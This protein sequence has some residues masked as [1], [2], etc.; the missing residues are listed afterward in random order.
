M[1]KRLFGL[2]V[3]LLT[4]SVI[5]AQVLSESK[6]KEILTNYQKHIKNIS[7]ISS[8][9]VDMMPVYQ[10]QLES[11]NIFMEGNQKRNSDNDIYARW[12]E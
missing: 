12:I 6:K 9:N 1:T 4:T 11:A 3:L 2:I 5:Q 8:E 10:Y 7:A